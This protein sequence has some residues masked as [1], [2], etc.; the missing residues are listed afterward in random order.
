MTAESISM[1]RFS[2]QKP[3]LPTVVQKK[4]N[5]VDGTGTVIRVKQG[6]GAVA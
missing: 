1:T 6:S 3:L 4:V 2:E 5:Y